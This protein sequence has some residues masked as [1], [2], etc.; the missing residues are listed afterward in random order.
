MAP[1]GGYVWSEAVQKTEEISN[2][3]AHTLAEETKELA[4]RTLAVARGAASGMWEGA[5]DAFHKTG[6]E[7]KEDKS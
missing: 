3:A 7:N 1:G 6:D 5:K 2:Q 4:D